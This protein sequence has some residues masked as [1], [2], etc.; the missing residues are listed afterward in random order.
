[1]APLERLKPRLHTWLQPLAAAAAQR[2]LTPN[3]LGLAGLALAA[4]GGAAV[5][6]FPAARPALLLLVAIVLVRLTLDLL[7]GLLAREHGMTSESGTLLNEVGEALAAVFLYL[8]LALHPGI[9]GWL[10]VLLVA[11]GLCAELAGLAALTIGAPRR[12]DGPFGKR[13]RALLFAVL[14]LI[15]AVDGSAAGWLPW[16]LVPA[17]L[18]TAVTLVNRLRGALAAAAGGPYRLLPRHDPS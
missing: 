11:L 4:A 14:A 8:P 2:G 5:A 7:D 9:A 17:L 15:L 1:M 6:A 13:D 3:R 10:I 18:L 16:L 12:V